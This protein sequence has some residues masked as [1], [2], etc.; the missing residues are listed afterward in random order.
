MSKKLI[1]VTSR[2]KS[3]DIVEA[4]DDDDAVNQVAEGMSDIRAQDFD[5]DTE[6]VKEKR[7]QY[8]VRVTITIRVD[9]FSDMGAKEAAIDK[10]QES[11]KFDDAGIS[12][13]SLSQ[14]SYDAKKVKPK[15]A[16][17]R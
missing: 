9:A 10:L 14:F 3:V 16:R 6:V 12:G 2:F 8:D 1:R 11:M 13:L 15:K 5:F 7:D 17:K 4:E